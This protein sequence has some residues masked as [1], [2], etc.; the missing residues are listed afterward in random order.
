MIRTSILAI[1]LITTACKQGEPPPAR[2]KAP[3]AT[4]PSAIT[5]ADIHVMDQLLAMLTSIDTAIK[6]EHDCAKAAGVV[7]D[8][9]EK[10]ASTIAV[11]SKVDERTR[12]DADA[13]A[14]AFANYGQKFKPLMEA[15]M[16]HECAKDAAYETALARLR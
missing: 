1:A 14:W 6:T 7:R 16:R 2:H 9:A 15:I 10:Y 4:R 8:T 11:V 12:A 13:E 5:D 3:P